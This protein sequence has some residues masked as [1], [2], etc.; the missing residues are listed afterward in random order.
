[1]AQQNTQIAQQL[2]TT[3]AIGL[4]GRTVSYTDNA[5]ALQTGKVEAVST[6]T[7]GGASLTVAGQTGIDPSSITSV[8]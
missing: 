1:M 5:G 7:D 3:N 6:T 4:I 2:S 8:S